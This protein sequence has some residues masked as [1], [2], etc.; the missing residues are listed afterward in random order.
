[1][2]RILSGKPSARCPF[3]CITMEKGGYWVG[4]LFVLDASSLLSNGHILGVPNRS[5]KENE[6][7]FS[8]FTHTHT[9]TRLCFNLGELV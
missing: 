9:H 7:L 4:V 2:G 5:Y 3:S 6:R 8:L 1:M